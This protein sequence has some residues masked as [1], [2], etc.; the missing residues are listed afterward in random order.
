M[1]E[2]K[3]ITSEGLD[4]K[5]DDEVVKDEGTENVHDSYE[6]L[7]LSFNDDEK[8]QIIP[9][10]LSSLDKFSFTL[11]G[12]HLRSAIAIF[13][14]STKGRIVRFELKVGKFTHELPGKSRIFVSVSGFDSMIT[15][16]ADDE[17]TE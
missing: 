15:V 2:S 5:L 17:M 4:V 11:S 16:T 3:L 10:T 9:C 1:S 13:D 8:E 6:R 12:M 14:A 7:H